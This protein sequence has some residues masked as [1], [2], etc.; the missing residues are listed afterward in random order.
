[1]NTEQFNKLNLLE[2][3]LKDPERLAEI[4]KQYKI[5]QA[6]I[7]ELYLKSAELIPRDVS[8]YMES[9]NEYIP[10][11]TYD[12]HR[13]YA[14][15]QYQNDSDDSENIFVDFYITNYTLLN[16][17]PNDSSIYFESFESSA[18]KIHRHLHK[19]KDCD[20]EDFY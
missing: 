13:I 14:H 18:C 1:M 11:K 20:I 7:E 4:N 5:I 6:E 3:L 16:P 12:G 8:A 19:F 2:A 9:I 15:W 10:Y 17:S